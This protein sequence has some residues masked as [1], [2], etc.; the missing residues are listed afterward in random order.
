MLMFS[1]DHSR[2]VLSFEQVAQ[3]N[4]KLL[5]ERSYRLVLIIKEFPERSTSW[6]VPT[7][8]L[9]RFCGM[10][11]F[12][13]SD[14]TTEYSESKTLTLLCGIPISNISI[15]VVALALNEDEDNCLFIFEHV[16]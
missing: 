4:S 8:L 15:S 11:Y 13:L 7:K 5:R 9:S 1:N 10:T 16:T 12:V 3:S 14:G 2:V 6:Y